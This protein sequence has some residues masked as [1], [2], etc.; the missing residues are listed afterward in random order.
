MNNTQMNPMTKLL[1]ITSGLL[2]AGVTHGAT[3]LTSGFDGN[4][5]AYVFDN[6]VNSGN[7]DNTNGS[8][9][10]TINDWSTDSAVSFISNLTAISTTSGGFAQTKSGTG[11][12]ANSNTVYISRNNFGLDANTERG[13]SF[14]FTLDSAFDLTNLNVISGHT[15]NTGNQDQAFAS[16]LNFTISGGTLG[17]SISDFS[18]ENYAN[19]PAYHSVNFDLTGNTLGP[20]TYTITVTQ[21]N[22]TGGSYATF[23][24]I[25]LE[26]TAVPEPSSTALIGLA[27]IG[28][29]LRRRR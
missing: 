25:T 24:G 7:T 6:A 26:G 21:T 8:S 22:A 2:L 12:Y 19:A 28:L 15:N 18:T 1:T 23:D 10:L 9:T 3:I 29:I 5:G 17:S 13:F 16:D 4:T 20:G 11:A 14:Q 27:G